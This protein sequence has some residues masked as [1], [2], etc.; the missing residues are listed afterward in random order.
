MKTISL[1]FLLFMSFCSYAQNS[2]IVDKKG[3]KTVVRDDATEIILI[4][5]RISYVLEG[6]TWP[7][8]VKFE[9]LDYASINGL[10]L[11]S[12]KI[13]GS[14]NAQ[15]YFVLAESKDKTL[16]ARSITVSSTSSS[17]KMTYDT[18]YYTM[19]VIDNKSNTVQ[20][21]DFRF[22]YKKEEEQT[23]LVSQLIRKHFAECTLVM[24]Y[25]K[26][27]E[28]NGNTLNMFNNTKIINCN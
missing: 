11:K 14:K 9:D 18:D 4:N 12:F 26:T 28:T 20:K 22:N 5:N 8:Y 21:V 19:L 6:K 10:L 15:V 2:Y 25:L 3:T 1:I 7:K 16:I 24:E 17:G 23:A 13:D 27:C